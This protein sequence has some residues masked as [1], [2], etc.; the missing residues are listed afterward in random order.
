MSGSISFTRKFSHKDWIDFVDSVQAGG[1]NGINGR[2]H[3]IEGDLDAISA[4]IKLIAATLQSPAAR[5]Q[6]LTLSPTLA[7][8]AEQPWQQLIGSVTTAVDGAAMQATASGFMPITLPNGATVQGLRVTGSS[9]GGILTVTLFRQALTGG[10]QTAV[11]QLFHNFPAGASTTAF[12]L[13]PAPQNAHVVID[14]ASQKYYLSASLV[15]GNTTLV[16]GGTTLNAFQI[17]YSSV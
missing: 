5:P 17:T 13:P 10:G 14:N 7:A 2:L 3:A 11:V 1:S 8:A 4:V 15:G 16:A 6:T 12:D 9:A